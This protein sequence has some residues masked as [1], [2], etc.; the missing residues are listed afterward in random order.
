MP[1]VLV[2]GGS[3][4]KNIIHGEFFQTSEYFDIIDYGFA[5]LPAGMN[6]D[7]M[8]VALLGNSQE[9]NVS[10]DELWVSINSATNIRVEKIGNTSGLGDAGAAFKVI[11]YKSLKQNIDIDVYMP[12]GT[13]VVDITI[14][15]IDL[16]KSELFFRG[17][18]AGYGTAKIAA[19]RIRF[20]LLNST[21]VRAE[22][23]TTSNNGYAYA[24][25]V[26]HG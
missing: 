11:E 8:I 6:R 19:A 24:T 18:T 23:A 7:N 16:E 25:V 22:R 1:D 13:S 15:E 20:G 17:S 12:G 4:I 10:R 9:S 5:S 26:E 3:N 14:P 2:S 21:T